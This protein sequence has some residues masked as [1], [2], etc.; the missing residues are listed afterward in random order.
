MR[1]QG[2]KSDGSHAP[3][4]LVQAEGIGPTRR[5]RT[6]GRTRPD[7]TYEFNLYP[8]QGYVITIVDPTVAA[9]S[10][11]GIVVHDGKPRADLDLSLIP[12]V[13]VRHCHR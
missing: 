7:G 12:G 6:Y 1:R 8:D 2:S 13:L 4:I 11:T 3:G 5:C 10:L 9:Q